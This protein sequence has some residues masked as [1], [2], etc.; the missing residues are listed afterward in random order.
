MPAL[1]IAKTHGSR[2]DIFVIAGAPDDHF[3]PADLI[4][5]ITT[6]CDRR[7]GLGSD[8]VYFVAD[9]GDGTA[10][11]WF[12]NPDGSPA[13]LCGNGMR[14]VGRLLLDRHQA[15]S[16]VVHTGPYSFTVRSA[17][18]TSHGVR[19]VSVELPPV[20]FT[21]AEPIVTGVQWPFLDQLLPAYH[22]TRTVSALA[23]P[24]S[25]LVSVVNSYRESELVQ[26]G[27]RVARNREVFPIGANTSFVLPL[28][29]AEVFIHTFERGA[30]LTPSCGSGIAASRAVLSRLGLAE[31]EQP[32]VVRNPGG[33]A[34]S[35]LQPVGEQWQPILEGNA[36]VVYTA[37]LDPAVLL[38]EAPIEFSGEANMQEIN[39]FASLNDENLKSLQAAGVN[40]TMI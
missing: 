17:P 32:V 21:P 10:Q 36:T 6:L 13:L 20:D 35:W 28:A 11:A 27:T 19:Q 29:E 34:R 7:R 14:C 31:P 1:S 12:Y 16:A 15:E 37:Q 18:T 24:N 4:R 9:H 38:G 26:T 22:L 23:V 25:H 33:P 30:G 39:A 8:G 2:N 40:P 5:A 3:A